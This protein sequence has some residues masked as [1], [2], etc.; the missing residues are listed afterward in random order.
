MS[1]YEPRLVRCDAMRCEQGDHREVDEASEVNEASEDE[2]EVDG[3]D[4][5]DD[6]DRAREWGGEDT[7]G[8]EMTTKR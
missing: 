5:E 7:E 4:S 6:S 8:T 2:D 1:V 3:R